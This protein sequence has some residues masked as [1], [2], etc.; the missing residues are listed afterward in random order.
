MMC[1]PGSGSALC[2]GLLKQFSDCSL[3]K[4]PRWLC[5][6]CV[7]QHDSQL[8]G[9]L[10]VGLVGHVPDWDLAG[11]ACPALTQVGIHQLTRGEF[12]E[13]VRATPHAFGIAA[14]DLDGSAGRR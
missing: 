3:V 9:V 8:D 5:G 10:L 14:G 2:H 12:G 13:L 11:L 1:G 6:Q 4:R 7:Y